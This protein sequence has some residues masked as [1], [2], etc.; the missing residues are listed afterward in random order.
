MGAARSL[1]AEGAWTGQPCYVIGGGPS[2]TSFNWDLLKPKRNLIA[3]NL[4]FTKVPH[5][6]FFF[7]EDDRVLTE[8]IPAKEELKKAWAEFKG[9]KLWHCLEESFKEK[10]LSACPDVHVIERKRRD[11]HWSASWE[12]GLSYSS[13]SA[14]GAINIAT[15]LNADPVYLLGIDCRRTKQDANWHNLYPWDWQMP[16][17]QDKNYASD[18]THWAALHTRNRRVVN[19]INPEFPSALECWPRVPWS[20]VL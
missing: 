13:N 16:E 3:I 6:D 17:G 4:A 18:F 15:I 20:E 11:K 9:I 5:A 19:L 14:I 10:V 2:L 12:E 8:L 1:P 7:T